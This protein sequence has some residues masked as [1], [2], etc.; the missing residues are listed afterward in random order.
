M[1]AIPS[2]FKGRT[3]VILQPHKQCTMGTEQTEKQG[4]SVKMVKGM[5]KAGSL[6]RN[7]GDRQQAASLGRRL[8]RWS[9]NRWSTPQ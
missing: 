9:G 8:Q 5:G 6:Q 2:A 1:G 7:P 4:S 3:D